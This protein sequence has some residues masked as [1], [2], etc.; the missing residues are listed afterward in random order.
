[1]IGGD[2]EFDESG[3]MNGG[4]EQSA[5]N[6]RWNGEHEDSGAELYEYRIGICC[7]D[8]WWVRNG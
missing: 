6:L 3:W 8:V 2:D 7:L 5:R 1:M 4:V